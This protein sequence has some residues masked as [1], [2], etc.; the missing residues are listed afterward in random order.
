MGADLGL[1]PFARHTDARGA[2]T[3]ALR[4]KRE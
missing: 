3:A 4:A 2:V 1:A